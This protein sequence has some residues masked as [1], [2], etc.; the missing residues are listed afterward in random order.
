MNDSDKEITHR[1]MN[2]QI[3]LAMSDFEKLYAGI[4]Y[5]F[6]RSNDCVSRARWMIGERAGESYPCRTLYPVQI[7]NGISAFNIDARRDDNFRKLQEYRNLYF[8]MDG[9]GNIVEV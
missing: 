1:V 9:R 8:S 5:K 4:G 2:G 6:K 3:C 7:D